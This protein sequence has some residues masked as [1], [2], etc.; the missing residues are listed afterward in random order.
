[1]QDYQYI[2][3]LLGRVKLISFRAELYLLSR[4]ATQ[5]E[6]TTSKLKKAFHHALQSTQYSISTSYFLMYILKPSLSPSIY[7]PRSVL[8]VRFLLLGWT[9][10]SSSVIKGVPNKRSPASPNPGMIQ[11]SSFNFSSTCPTV[12]CTSGWNFSSSDRPFEDAN[13]DKT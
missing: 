13:T 3:H 10:S 7:G 8:I 6:T 5:G 4:T 9:N 12:T 2:S 11:P 1:M